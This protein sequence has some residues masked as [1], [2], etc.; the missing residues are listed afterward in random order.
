M[1][2]LRHF[3]GN[4]TY[5]R[6]VEKALSKSGTW[7]SRAYD[8]NGY[9]KAW[10]KW[11]KCEKPTFETHGE[12]VYSGERFKYEKPVLFWGFNKMIEYSAPYNIRLPS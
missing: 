11:A 7:F 5:G 6:P 3:G 10:A 9:G 8:F 4:D 2:A 1:K 12:N